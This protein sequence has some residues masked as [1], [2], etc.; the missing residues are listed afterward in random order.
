MGDLDLCPSSPQA[1]LENLALQ[2]FAMR[3][4][5]YK[6]TNFVS[7]TLTSLEIIAAHVVT[8]FCYRSRT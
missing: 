8:M 1:P 2:L 6:S 3:V 4:H 7:A 5:R